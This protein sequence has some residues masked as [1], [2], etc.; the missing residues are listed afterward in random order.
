MALRLSGLQKHTSTYVGRIRQSRHPAKNRMA[1]HSGYGVTRRPDKAK[2]P[3]GKTEW[4]LTMDI[5]SRVG[6]IRQ[7]RHPAK[8]RMAAHNGYEVVRLPDKRKRHPAKNRMATH[9]GYGVTRRPDKAK[10][11]SGKTEWRPTI[12]MG[13]RVGRISASAIRQTT[14]AKATDAPLPASG[15]QTL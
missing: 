15:S 8:N 10:P 14:P 3:S 12:D 9:N 1:T 2:P 13:S 7:S 5:G 6:R 4:R 11:P